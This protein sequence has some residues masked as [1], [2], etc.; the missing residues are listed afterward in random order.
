[1]AVSETAKRAD[2]RV[3]SLPQCQ[4]RAIAA[5]HGYGAIQY[6]VIIGATHQQ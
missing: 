2:D 6:G 1:M 3:T 5:A 4:S